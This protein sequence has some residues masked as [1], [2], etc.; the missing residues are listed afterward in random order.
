MKKIALLL[1][2]LC[3]AIVAQAQFILNGDF[4]GNLDSEAV[5]ISNAEYNAQMPYS[6]AYGTSESIDIFS[7]I[8]DFVSPVSGNYCIGLAVSSQDASRCESISL[9]LSSQVIQGEHY[10]ISFFH[11]SQEG[12]PAPNIEIGISAAKN[13]FGKTVGS[14][15]N[16]KIQNQWSKAVIEFTA[17][18]NADN[19]TIRAHSTKKDSGSFL[20]NFSLEKIDKS[21]L[22]E[23]V[24]KEILVYPNPASSLVSIQSRGASKIERIDI[25]NVL[26]NKVWQEKLSNT[27]NAKIDIRKINAGIYHVQ[28]K[29]AE[30][31][32]FT[33]KLI[34]N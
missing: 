4:E 12:L 28:I 16:S 21:T 33:K 14:L 5:N 34:K 30:G 15:V 20:D 23:S 13:D 8:G 22:A 7:R 24:N 17:P 6:T 18:I 10:V 31:N 26:G 29:T 27:A 3:C 11:K 9:D 2:S 25:F 1:L 32:I 19:V